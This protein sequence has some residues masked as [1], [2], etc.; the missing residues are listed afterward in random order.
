M[1]VNIHCSIS[2]KA[3]IT[4][5]RSGRLRQLFDQILRADKATLTVG[6]GD[7]DDVPHL[8]VPSS[9]GDRFVTRSAMRDW[10]RP[11]TL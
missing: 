11:M 1:K 3:R 5:W 2:V 4:G 10:W 8:T 7:A 9:H 6:D